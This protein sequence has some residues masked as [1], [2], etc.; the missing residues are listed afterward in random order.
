[1]IIWLNGASGVGK[2]SVAQAVIDLLT[3]YKMIYLDA[4]RYFPS[5]VLIH[6]GGVQPHSN[7][8]F[9]QYFR[10]IIESYITLHDIIL[11]DMKVA[12]DVSKAELIDYFTESGTPFLHVILTAN[13]D[14][15][16]RRIEQDDDNIRPSSVKKEQL[17]QIPHTMQYFEE[18]FKEAKQIDTSD[19]NVNDVAN[20]LVDLIK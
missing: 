10:N 9:C 16:Q 8:G 5:Y 3:N 18:N 17:N 12:H 20:T 2:S 1:M 6:G 14:A 13:T 19:R 11:V 4:D 7:I 15:L